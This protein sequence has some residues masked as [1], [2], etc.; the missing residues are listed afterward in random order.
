MARGDNVW[1]VKQG[2]RWA[3]KEEGIK[4]PISIHNKQSIAREQGI[5]Q[6]KQN[7]S[8]FIMQNRDH[9][10]REKNSYGNDPKDIKG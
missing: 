1:V 3:V 2:K 6:A 4:T 5:K 10:I 7:K 9:A 8:E